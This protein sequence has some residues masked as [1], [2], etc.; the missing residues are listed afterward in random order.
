[1]QLQENIMTRGDGNSE[2]NKD[3]ADLICKFIVYMIKMFAGA[4]GLSY[5]VAGSSFGEMLY[6][7]FIVSLFS[8]LTALEV[9]GFVYFLQRVAVGVKGM[10]GG[11]FLNATGVVNVTGLNTTGSDP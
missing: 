10:E 8:N 7:T 2:Q 6:V 4:I 3:C 1:M 11:V 9:C 5:M